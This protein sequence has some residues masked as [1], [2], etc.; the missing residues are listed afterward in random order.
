MT[1]S[2]KNFWSAAVFGLLIGGAFTVVA[3]A[4]P[5]TS[6]SNTKSYPPINLGPETQYHYGSL[7]LGDGTNK[8]DNT[9]CPAGS[10]SI[11][12][13]LLLDR[14]TVRQNANFVSDV[15][16]D[17]RNIFAGLL[18]V[19]QVSVTSTNT[20]L[21]SYDASGTKLFFPAGSTTN[22]INGNYCTT[23]TNGACP[24]GS[25]LYKYDASS[26]KSTCRYINPSR[27]PGSIGNCTT[28][29]TNVSLIITTSRVHDPAFCNGT[30]YYRASNSSSGYVWFLKGVSESE[31]TY[32]GTGSER[33]IRVPVGNVTAFK[34]YDLLVRDSSYPASNASLEVFSM[35]DPNCTLQQGG[36]TGGTGQ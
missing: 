34:A 4:E 24:V 19:A 36:T 8:V 26:N 18:R 6:P 27:S 30:R 5:T 33:S 9:L 15:I 7:C 11:K 28:P 16:V 3:F 31:W 29:A 22:L 12:S 13:H 35:R 32:L 20:G 25:V 10:M 17:K 14:L 1:I 2:K 21:P 23:A